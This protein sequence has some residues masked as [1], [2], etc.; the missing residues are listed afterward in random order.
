MTASAQTVHVRTLVRT[1]LD[2]SHEL[3]PGKLTLEISQLIPDVDLRDA[4]EQMLPQIVRQEISFSR[5]QDRRHVPDDTHETPAPARGTNSWA[6]RIREDWRRQLDQ[7][8]VGASGWKFLRDF[9]ADDCDF[10][11]EL[12]ER[13]SAAILDRAAR[14]RRLAQAVR[15]N[16]VAMIGD[17]PEEVLRP[18]LSE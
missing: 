7:R 6:A 18:L 1:V 9:T 14:L 13:E 3:D 5:M 4:V 16:Q 11:A 12:R 2:E 8:Y 15:E 10:A 17:L